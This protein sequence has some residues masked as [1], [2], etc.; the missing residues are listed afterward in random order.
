[1]GASNVEDIYELSPLQRGMLLHSAHDGA[2]DMYLSQQTY[3][4]T[5]KLDLEALV[6]A[7]Q[8]VSDRHPALRTSFHW[9]DL[10]KPLQVVHREVDL[11]VIHH[12]WPDAGDDLADR[13]ERL[14]ASDAATGFDLTVPPLQRLHV[15]RVGDERFGLVW[16]FHHLLMDGWSIP[17]LLGELLGEYRARTAGWPTSPPAPP[18]R[19]YIA[20]LQRQDPEASRR[21][22]T[23][24]LD[25]STG[26]RLRPLA[27]ADPRQGTGPIDRREVQ[28]PAA[29]LDGLREAAVRHRVTL[30]TLAYAVWAAVIRRHS[31]R[32]D[33]VLGCVTSGRPA[34]LPG[35]EGMIGVLANTLPLPVEVPDDGDLGDWL[36]RVQDTAAQ[37]RRH[38][39]TS[40]ADIK[41]WVGRSGQELFDS[42]LS[43]DNY[44]I[45]IDP[46]MLGGDLTFRP[47]VLFDK[48]STPIAATF[49]PDSGA[50]QMLVHRDRFPAGF[51]DDLVTDLTAA[52]EAVTS[53]D[54]VQ[55]V[56][57]A[58]PAAGPPPVPATVE[59]SAAGQPPATAVEERIAEVYRQVLERP[60]VDVT[61]SFFAL[62]GDSF[63]AVRAAGRIEGASVA[64]IAAHPSVRELARAIAP[65]E[66][67]APEPDAD[68]D[69][70][71]GRLEELLARKR[72]EKA[73]RDETPQLVPVP[74]EPSM[75][76]THQQEAMW[77]MHQVAPH[78]TSYH[79]PIPLRLHGNLDV[80]AL[81][82]A[83]HTLV[84]RHESLRTRFV[85][86]HG[87]PRQVI[88][89]PP[90][91]TRLPVTELTEDQVEP[92]ARGLYTEP[93]DL[94]AAPAFRVGV[95]RVAPDDFVV[96]MVFHHIV[97]DGWSGRILGDELSAAY[98]AVR[99]GVP[100]KLPPVRVQPADL[101]VWQRR[102][103]AGPE[104]DR[105]IGH[106]R[107]ALAGLSTV[108]FSADRPRPARPNG[109]GANVLR[110][111]PAE[112]SAAVRAYTREHRVSLLSVL[113]AGL[114]SVL[115]RWTGQLDLPVG[116]L[117]TGRTSA[118]IESMVGY[119]GSIVVL[120]PDLSGEPSFAE[121]IDRCNRVVLD[122]TSRQDVPFLLVVDALRPERVTGRNPLFQ[123]GLTLHP[124]G[125][126]AALR[127]GDDVTGEQFGLHDEYTLWDMAVDV[128]DAP[129]GDLYLSIDYSA[130][131]YDPER[132]TR[133][134]DH[135]ATALTAGLSD[136]DTRATDLEIMPAAERRQALPEAAPVT[137]AP[138][139]HEQISAIAA[140]TPHAPAVL[141]A[142]GAGL[143]YRELDRAADRLAHRLRERGARP[144]LLVE[145]RVDGPLRVAALLAVWRTGACLVPPGSSAGPASALVVTAADNAAGTDTEARFVE[146]DEAAPAVI[147]GDGPE[148]IV[149]SY[150]AVR[151]RIVALRD[152]VP[153]EP[154]DRVLNASPEGGHAWLTELFWALTCG[155][156][157]VLPTP[158]DRPDA[159]ELGITALRTG[160]AG[161]RE[162]IGAAAPASLRRVICGGDAVPADTV[163]RFHAT[164]PG[165]RLHLALGSTE[166]G[167][168]TLSP[169]PGL[170]VPGARALVLDD[171]LRPAP[172]GVP[173]RLFVAGD[174]VADGYLGAPARTARTFVA[175]PHGTGPMCATGDLVRRHADGHLELLGDAERRVTV[176]GDRIDPQR[177]EEA[178]ADHPLVRHGVVVPAGDGLTAYV[179]GWH[180]RREPDP[181]GLREFLAGRLPAH[182]LPRVLV[183]VAD[184]PLTAAGTIDRDR[185]PQAAP[186]PDSVPASE[187]TRQWLAGTWLEIVGTPCGGGTFWE[188]GASSLQATRLVARVR[189]GLGVNLTIDELFAHPTLDQLAAWID[190]AAAGPAAPAEEAD[191]HTALR[192]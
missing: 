151:A 182:L 190:R 43:V 111:L 70:E 141:A 35:V 1:M 173:G 152:G 149:V 73:R 25:S 80:A 32:A 68:L 144:G 8:S 51:V 135:F 79:V 191:E 122:A 72:A 55:Q 10:D 115:H 188:L 3:L 52:L 179:C 129:D 37:L 29:L 114:L 54:R 134:A 17:I 168:V 93:F 64:L 92:W 172:I 95:G 143:T 180:G 97:T 165:A 189:A 74:R 153:L 162:L 30:G 57:P 103:L 181:H 137:A 167:D 145:A 116:S 102:W 106:W 86:E 117:L 99:A 130:E 19:D 192:H 27:P 56:A 9:E 170:P 82:R 112:T 132:I 127:L 78:W 183:T 47:D 20:W 164:W 46:A 166:T 140:R 50:V 85:A 107:E 124:P 186:P 33:V 174:A 119:L 11:P 187:T 40:L 89:P 66:T 59:D 26:N 120:R 65:E 84:V 81:E 101:A 39:Y 7:W 139:V 110:V 175:G 34:D 21:W 161:L 23:G 16:S 177:I 22:W 77:F 4:V 31:D 60:S 42:T 125:I 159:A 113:H 28:L 171:R 53:A 136:P 169:H 18:Y 2:P 148:P 150:R 87:V 75:V 67:A 5:G 163:R 178:L 83:M 48:T 157:V 13:L 131:L 76:C 105:Q 154:G 133:F 6:A 24:L 118:E 155:A 98:A 61:M 128:T 121:L 90:A 147:L 91:R 38:E 62:G 96:V 176:R 138:P 12:D 58:R 108:D 160:P 158:G 69:D 88:D 14:R 104:R 156:T 94:A 109:A 71:I 41:R 100:A 123:I 126:N 146:P 142:D 45:T 49:T 15:V 36:R 184:L 185:L 63:D 44:S